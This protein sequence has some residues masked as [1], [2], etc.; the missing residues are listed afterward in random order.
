MSRI[1]LYLDEDTIKQAL[2]QALRNA[3]LDI[4]TVADADRLGYPDEEQLQ[5]LRI[6]TT[7]C[8]SECSVSETFAKRVPLGLRISKILRYTPFRSV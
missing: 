3:D 4:V 7:N 1:C 8:H 2:I 6:L 5:D